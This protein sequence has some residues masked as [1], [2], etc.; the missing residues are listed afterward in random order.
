M[1]ANRLLS[2]FAAVGF[3]AVP[4]F[5]V[6]PTSSQLHYFGATERIRG[7]DPVTSADTT[8]SRAVST[9]Y[10][11]L[12]EYEYL[13]RPYTVRPLLAEGMPEISPDGLTY[14]IRVK[15]GIK[16]ADDACFPDGKGRELT[17]EDFIYSWKRVADVNNHST[18]FW[19]FE[20][21]IVGLN[22][23]HEK[24]AKGSANYDE[25]V[26]GIKA[27]DRYT[28]QIKLTKPFPQLIWILTMSYTFAV[29][30]EAV[31]YYHEEFLNHPV[32][33]GPYIIQDWKWR[34]YG[35][36][37]VKNPAYHG[38]TYPTRGT[39]EDKV[40]GL[41][42][43]AGRP[44]PI[45]DEVTLNVISDPSTEWL[46]FLAGKI[47]S[48]G[49]SRDNFDAVVT[50]QRELTPELKAKGIRLE[51]T[52]Q[53]YTTYFGFNMEDPVVGMSKDPA[54]NE[55]HRKL[56]QALS[57]S[58]DIEKWIEFYNG[59]MISANG[60]IPPN[61]AGHDEHKP[62]PYA[63]DLKRGRQLM[64][65]AGY[66][67]GRDPK[68]GKRLVITL[69]LGNA[70]DPEAR[71]SVD[72][73]ASFFDQIGVELKPSFNNWPEFLKKMERRQ[74]QMFQLGWVADYPDAENFLTLF[75][76]KSASPGPNHCN[77]SN[78]KFDELFDRARVMQDGPERTAL[79]QQM[80]DMVI[81]DA[82]WIFMTYPL[83][84]GLHQPWLKNFKPHDFPYPFMKFYKVDPTKMR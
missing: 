21:H 29:P 22:E 14:T 34:N 42:D 35:I 24:S 23:F 78:P 76:S 16:F 31:D 58:I 30:R 80:A 69:E 75:Y 51:K 10:E 49:I 77:Y 1:F 41:L 84:F 56:R 11:G 59:R 6:L 4:A 25:P 8:S 57:C 73:L 38:D 79:Y 2:L 74:N 54:E 26:E 67:D 66:P 82:P 52:P 48:A 33:T 36:T 3:G 62:R 61:M 71:Q 39:P 32:G 43:D 7:F 60:P 64:A 53:L 5:A 17:A 44:A 27:P 65:E 19:I 9:V 50:S 12:Y 28:I 20:D 83:S 45:L 68:T 72:L 18:C 15:K 37:Y 13:L 55:R 70:S 47:G 81:A 46:M 40:A 63:F